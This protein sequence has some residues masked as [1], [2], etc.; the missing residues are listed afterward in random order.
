MDGDLP[1]HLPADLRH[2]KNLTVGHHLIVG[3]KTWQSVG[4]PLPKRT[5]VVV[6]RDPDYHVEGVIVV[7]SLAEALVAARSDDEPFVAGGAGLYR[8]ALVVADRMYL[9]RIH[10]EFKADT[11]FPVVR[12]RAWVLQSEE[13]TRLIS[14]IGTATPFRYSGG[15]VVT[16]RRW[17]IRYGRRHLLRDVFCSAAGWFFRIR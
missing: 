2:F 14:R 8:E 6:T 13:R 10:A 3:R 16:P 11:F 12:R 5:M 9:T 15:P 4:K 17:S 1:W 7:H